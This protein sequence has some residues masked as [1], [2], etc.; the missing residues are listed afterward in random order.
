MQTRQ[1]TATSHRRRNGSLVAKPRPSV[2]TRLTKK[3]KKNTSESPPITLYTE[4][5]KQSTVADPIIASHPHPKPTVGLGPNSYGYIIAS[6]AS[7]AARWLVASLRYYDI[8]TVIKLDHNIFNLHYIIILMTNKAFSKWCQASVL[9]VVH[10]CS[11]RI[12]EIST[13]KMKSLKDGTGIQETVA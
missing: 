12:A 3:K 11:V 6:P 8:M 5:D 4:T 13:V 1:Y 9:L 10:S 7:K 2:Q